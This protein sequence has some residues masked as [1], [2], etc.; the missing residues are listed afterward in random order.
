MGLEAE[1][2][3]LELQQKAAKDAADNRIAEAKHVMQGLELQ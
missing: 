2:S 3:N 1:R